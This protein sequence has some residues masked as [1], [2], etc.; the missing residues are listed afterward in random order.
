MQSGPPSKE[1]ATHRI[2]GTEVVLIKEDHYGIRFEYDDGQTQTV[3]VG[4]PNTAEGFADA[5]VGQ[6][7]PIGSSPLEV[8]VRGPY[9]KVK[10]PG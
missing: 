10:S 8:S 7:I 9:G 1:V 3:E 4:D 6:A 2:V 5:L